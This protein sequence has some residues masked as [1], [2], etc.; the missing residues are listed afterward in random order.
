LNRL[1][2]PIRCPIRPPTHRK[3]KPVSFPRRLHHATP[4]WVKGAPCFHIRLRVDAS[5]DQALTTAPLAIPLLKAFEHYHSIQRWHCWLVLLMPDHLHALL[6]VSR[7][8]SM[9]EILR[10]WKRYTASRYRIN[11]QSNYFDHRIRNA[12]DK[13]TTWIYISQNPVR[14]GLWRSAEDW[15]WVWPAPQSN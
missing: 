15:P 12:A 8:Q 1:S 5:C 7:S 13:R 4:S 2:E 9:S 14:K 11:W 3:P 10:A 6:T